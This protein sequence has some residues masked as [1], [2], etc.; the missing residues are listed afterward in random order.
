VTFT[1]TGTL[2]AVEPTCTEPSVLREMVLDAGDL[3]P[4]GSWPGDYRNGD[5]IMRLADEGGILRV[6][7]GQQPMDV[8]HYDGEVYFT[9]I[10]GQVLFP[11]RLTTDAAGRRYLVLDGRAYIH[12]DDAPGR[13]GTSSAGAR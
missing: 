7:N 12:L 10:G 2:N 6:T 1:G 3:A 9:S 4:S 13:R 5:Q 11:M 8:T